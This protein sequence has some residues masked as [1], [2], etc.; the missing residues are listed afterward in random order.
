MLGQP[1]KNDALIE[2]FDRM[3][4]VYDMYVAPFSTPIFD[5]ALAMIRPLV[6]EAARVL[7]AGCGAGRELERMARLVPRGEV[8]GIDLA[9]GMVNAAFRSA[10]AHG[11]QNTAFF[12]SD[13]AELPPHFAGQFDLAYNS[14][15][16]HHYPEPAAAA[17]SIFRALRPGGVYCV[18]DPGPA[19]FT[20]TAAPLSRW[21]DPGWIG[22]HTPAQFRDLF[23][24]AGFARFA[25][26]EVLPGFC[27]SIGQK[28]A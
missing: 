2:E 19:W 23:L 17:R 18:V 6:H 7:D 1:T 16:H 12:Q 3:A 5:E 28:E 13:V 27:V 15:A 25:S 9:A 4:E 26:A 22:F 24:Q 20:A 10:R 8:V 11:L 14:L 21:G